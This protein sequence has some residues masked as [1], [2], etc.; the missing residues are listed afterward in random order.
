MYLIDQR[1]VMIADENNKRLRQIAAR[2]EWSHF[3]P[4][5]IET[6]VKKTI[7]GRA[8]VVVAQINGLDDPCLEL[9][10]KLRAHWRP[11]FCLVI[12]LISHEAL[13]VAVLDA[14]ASCYLTN[15]DELESAVLMFLDVKHQIQCPNQNKDDIPAPQWRN[16]R[17]VYPAEKN[18]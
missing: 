12:A 3:E 10:R 6:L 5:P 16:T 15:L 7:R 11:P 18:D 17:I 2:N 14:G 8:K 1:I 4:G 13:E 9:I